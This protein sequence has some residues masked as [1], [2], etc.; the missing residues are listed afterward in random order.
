MNRQ[1][2]ANQNIR[3][4]AADFL[5]RSQDRRIREYR[6]KWENN[7]RDGRLEPFPVHLDIEST[8]ICNLKCPFCA[9]TRASY[10]Q[11]FM[12]MAM[13]REIIDEG[14]VNGLYSIKLNFR[15]EPLLHPGIEEMVAYAKQRNIV[16]VFFNTNATCL[17]EKRAVGLIESGLDRLIVSFEGYSREIYEENR[18][19]ADF[20]VVVDNVRNLCRLKK[21][22]GAKKPIVRLQ[23][24]AIDKH[25]QYLTHY[26]RFWQEYA[27]EITCIDL[28]DEAKSYKGIRSAKWK[29]P[30]PW[31]RLLITWDG[32]ILTC[33]FVNLSEE[34]YTWKG[35]G[36]FGQTSIQASWQCE[37]MD[38]IRKAQAQYSAHEIEPCM[39][40][41]HRGTE[42]LK[43]EPGTAQ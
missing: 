22:R 6:E 30:Y 32:T 8:S 23:T 42:I 7:P 14:I 12:K 4:L 5:S 15:G 31:L 3:H 34:Q 11:G 43:Q 25:P 37:K 10:P 21:E 40:C 26:K 9:G 36:S 18:V 29:C 41:S 38:G 39:L 28:R 27:D 2:Q 17:T 16:D 24:V 19:G 1:T 35:F 13:F 20:D 33:P